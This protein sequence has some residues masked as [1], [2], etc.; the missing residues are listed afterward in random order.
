M[1][2]FLHR[3]ELLLS[4]FAVL[5]R[6][7]VLLSVLPIFSSKSIPAQ[8]KILLS[9]T[10]AF[11]MFPM[12]V[13]TGKIDPA[14]ALVWGS[15]LGGIIKVIGLEALFGLAL[16]FVAKLSF[17]TVEIA[18]DLAGTFM[19]FAN[20][21]QF[22]PHQ[23]SQTQV[24]AKF[25]MALA[26]LL[27]LTINGHHIML[28]AALGSYGVVGMGKVH[29]G[30]RFEEI[31]LA[32]SAESI[33]LGLQ[34]AAPMALALTSVNIVY[35]VMAKAMPQLNILILS[36]SVS[37]L[38]GLFVLGLSEPEFFR[39]ASGVFLDVGDRMLAVMRSLKGA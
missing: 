33:R 25:Q 15:S 24:I 34:M 31:L 3:Q 18:G 5:V 20:A 32:M 11:V 4:F 12:L 16:G 29:F 37:A 39:V 2:D 23:E 28:E 13:S 8:V 27:F 36:F 22:D 30:G 19:G 10:I 21:S 6:F 38:I 1:F 35:A 9:L 17:D 14:E 7:S 26:T